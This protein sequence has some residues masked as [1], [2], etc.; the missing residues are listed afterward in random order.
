MTPA[1]SSPDMSLMAYGP[2]RA[3]G[4]HRAD[5]GLTVG[6][7]DTEGARDSHADARLSPS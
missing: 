5:L 6:A 7:A 2:E 3:L 4:D 1:G